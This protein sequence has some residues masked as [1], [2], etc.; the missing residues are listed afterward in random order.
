MNREQLIARLAGYPSKLHA[1]VAPLTEEQLL[2]RPGEGQ[3]S[4]K[5]ILCH[6]RDGEEVRAARMRRV[7]E[8]DRPFLPG[9]DQE[10]YARDRGYQD[11]V[12]GTVLPRLVDHRGAQVALLRSLR[13]EA[14]ARPATHEESGEITLTDLAQGGVDHDAEHLE[15]I[16]RLRDAQ[17]AP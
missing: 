8:E 9:F 7:V 14:W 2:R 3:W 12:T 10:A 13:P 1:L 16:R 5:E 4:I 6:L 15:E 17:Q 11:E